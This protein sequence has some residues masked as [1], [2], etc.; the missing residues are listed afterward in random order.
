[1]KKPKAKYFLRKTKDV[2]TVESLNKRIF[3]SDDPDISRT[4][5]FWLLYRQKVPIG[6]CSVRPISRSILFFSRAGLLYGHRGY[7]LH[8]RMIKNRIKWAKENGYKKI[9]TYTIFSNVKSARNLIKLGFELYEPEWAYAGKEYL[10]F[11]KT[12]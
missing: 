2:E 4:S 11:M 9:I 5:T 12:L 3:P 10:Y 8:Q 6:F 7:G 1:M